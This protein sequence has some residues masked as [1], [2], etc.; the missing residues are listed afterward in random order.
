MPEA[1]SYRPSTIW[2]MYPKRSYKEIFE[3][4]QWK[5]HPFIQPLP[6]KVANVLLGFIK[7]WEGIDEQGKILC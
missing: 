6:K 3:I 7:I 2:F 4:C 5:G 1:L